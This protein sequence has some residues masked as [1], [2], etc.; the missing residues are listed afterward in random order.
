MI[1]L[2]ESGGR[3]VGFAGRALAG[4]PV[5]LNS[6]E[7]EVFHKREILFGFPQ[8]RDAIRSRSRVVV[9]EGYFDVLAF[10]AAGVEEV[11]SPMG[12][13][14]TLE[15]ARLLAEVT[16]Q[17]VLAFDSDPPGKE[18]VRRALPALLP[19]GLAVRSLALPDGHDP[20][21][22]REQEGDLAL[23]ASLAR[24]EDALGSELARLAAAVPAGDTLAHAEA[25]T[26]SLKLL[27]LLPEAALRMSYA[28]LAGQ[29]LDVPVSALLAALTG[30]REARGP[31]SPK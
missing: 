27:E 24:A 8:A 9:V 7:S 1:P 22:L 11:V 30:S 15:Q 19:S 20:A 2:R 26:A 14:L 10:A 16:Q 13:H 21:S 23:V 25:I 12:T 17:V 3:L 28:R 4:E 29:L 6:P 5:Y 31:V 18:A